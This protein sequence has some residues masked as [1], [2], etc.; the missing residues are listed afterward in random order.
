MNCSS[1]ERRRFETAQPGQSTLVLKTRHRRDSDRQLR[2]ETSHALKRVL[3]V[4][5]NGEDVRYVE[6]LPAIGDQYLGTG[7]E[8][9]VVYDVT[10]DDVGHIV[11]LEL[12]S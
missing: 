1:T 9:C 2:R 10:Q 6:D 7:G 5:P 3:F 8:L 12:S 4:L 11:R